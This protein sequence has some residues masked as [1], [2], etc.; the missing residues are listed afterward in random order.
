MKVA[1]KNR[2]KVDGF[3]NLAVLTP[4]DQEMRY[5]FNENACI[6]YYARGI[7][8]SC[9]PCRSGI[10]CGGPGHW[11]KD[12]VLLRVL[13]Y[14]VDDSYD[15]VANAATDITSK[16]SAEELADLQRAEALRA[17]F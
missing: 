12:S 8:R 7:F 16:L 17:E 1:V 10:A 2:N 11:Y 15:F 13:F 14:T 5:S 6:M 3:N 9:L 4:A